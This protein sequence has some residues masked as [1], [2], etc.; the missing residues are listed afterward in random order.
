MPMLLNTPRNL[1]AKTHFCFRLGIILGSKIFIDFTKYEFTECTNRL[2]KEIAP[3]YETRPSVK[4]PEVIKALPQQ[5]VSSSKPKSPADE[6][7]TWT[8]ERVNKWLAEKE[9]HSLIVE[10]IRPANGVL[11]HQYHEI[12]MTCPEFFYNSISSSKQVKFRDIAF[13][14]CELKKLFS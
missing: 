2:N 6:V 10:N 12:Q 9:I 11:L 7:L 4:T 3:L 5:G 13:F 1:I 8:E 14:S